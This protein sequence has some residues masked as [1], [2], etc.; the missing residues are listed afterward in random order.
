MTDEPFAKIAFTDD[1]GRVETLW[2][3]HVG[4]DRYRLDN[5]PWYQYG[6]SVGDIIEAPAG[7]DGFPAFK[8]VIE[9]SG[10]RTVRVLFER[11]LENGDPFLEAVKALGCGFEGAHGRLISIGVP[12]AV[13]LETVTGFLVEQG[14][15][16][17][18][19]DP[20]YEQLHGG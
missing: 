8:R 11:V 4:P 1:E 5:S 12:P 18:Y 20:T 6:V 13:D 9:K 7:A 19:A 14:V 17:E 10:Y 16:W 15:K 2:A 3:V